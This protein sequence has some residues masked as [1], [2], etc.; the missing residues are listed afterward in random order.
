MF[1]A[2]TNVS[3]KTIQNCYRKAGF[4]TLSFDSL[5]SLVETGASE[6]CEAS[7]ENMHTFSP[8]SNMDNETFQAFVDIDHDVPVTGELTDREILDSVMA[9]IQTNS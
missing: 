3:Q 2:W 9:D 1:D 8:P 7:E 5:L 6:E 4:S